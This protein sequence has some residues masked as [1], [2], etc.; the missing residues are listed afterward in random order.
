MSKRTVQRKKSYHQRMK[1]KK[2]NYRK[3]PP[4]FL[5]R[6]RDGSNLTKE[7]K[8][9]RDELNRDYGWYSGMVKESTGRATLHSDLRKLVT[10]YNQVFISDDLRTG[11]VFDGSSIEELTVCTCKD[12]QEGYPVV[13][14]ELKVSWDA[15]YSL[16]GADILSEKVKEEYSSWEYKY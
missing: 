6:T 16:V 9:L 14:S 10:I 1:D 15:Y 7:Y 12:C 2:R 5:Y 11:V 8:K 4:R 13:E 3:Y